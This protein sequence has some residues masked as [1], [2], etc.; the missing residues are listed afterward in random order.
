MVLRKNKAKIPLKDSLSISS[1][2]SPEEERPNGLYHLCGVVHHVGNTAF[3]G[4]YT[5]CAKRRLVEESAESS[6]NVEEQWV[7]FDDAEGER[8]TIDYVIGDK[9]NKENCYMALYELK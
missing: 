5:T 1:F 2:F 6:P 8:R 3:S 7:L 9:G 4:H